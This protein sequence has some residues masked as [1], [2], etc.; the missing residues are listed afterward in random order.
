[1]LTYT[2]GDAYTGQFKMGLRHGQGRFTHAD[3]T[4][5]EGNWVDGHLETKLTE[6]LKSALLPW[7]PREVRTVQSKLESIGVKTPEQ[8]RDRLQDGSLNVL[9]GDVGHRT[10]YGATMAKLRIRVQTWDFPEADEE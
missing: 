9:L 5:E 10:F 3:G 4:F 7:T 6:L 2:N 1:M 8:L